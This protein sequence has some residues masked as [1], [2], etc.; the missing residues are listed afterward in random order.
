MHDEM[1]GTFDAEYGRM[2]GSLGVEIPK[3]NPQTATTI[4]YGFLEPPTEIIRI[5]DLW[6]STWNSRRRHPN[7]EDNLTTVSTHTPYTGTCSK[8][9]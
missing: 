6:H 1:G 7:M 8:F 4:L 2:S 3:S 9:S 5:N